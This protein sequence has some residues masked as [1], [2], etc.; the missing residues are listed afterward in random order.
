M[1]TRDASISR[2][3]QLVLCAI[4]RAA[5]SSVVGRCPDR[6][7]AGRYEIVAEGEG[8]EP[9]R[10][11]TWLFSRQLPSTARP[12]LHVVPPYLHL[13]GRAMSSGVIGGGW[14]GLRAGG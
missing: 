5:V 10:L 11:I 9:P 12:S 4:R 13:F 7:H 1:Y 14:F 2:A 3:L 8:F 6:G